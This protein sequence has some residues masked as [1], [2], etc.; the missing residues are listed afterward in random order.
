[1]EACR[2]VWTMNTLHS[3]FTTYM[4]KQ[5]ENHDY[6]RITNNLKKLVHY[7]QQ[8]DSKKFSLV[9]MFISFQFQNIRIQF[10]NSFMD[11]LP[12]CVK[13]LFK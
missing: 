12:I 3:T 7:S 5:V 10:Y 6:S 9:I 2:Q 13:Y 11:N 4:S 1:M 8:L